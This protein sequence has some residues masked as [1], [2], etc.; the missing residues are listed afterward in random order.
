MSNAAKKVEGHGKAMSG[1]RSDKLAAQMEPFDSFWEGPEDVEKGYGSFKAFYRDNY[2]KH[3][4]PNKDAR[5]LVVS[6]GPGY[7]VN[8][9]N[10]AGYQDVIG[11]D[12]FDDKIEH[13]RFHGLNCIQARAFEYL[14]EQADETFDVIFCEQEL[15][16][17]TKDEMIEFLGLARAKLRAGGQLICH[18]LNGA[19]PIV[20]AETLAQNWDHQ[21]TFTSY[22]LNQVLEHTG[23]D[24]QKIF[25][26]HLYV[27][28]K[29]PA[30]YVA[31]GLTA[32]LHFVFQVLFKIYGK[33]N[34]IFEKKIAAVA[35]KPAGDSGSSNHLRSV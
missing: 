25:G 23:F 20:G 12:S 34:K 32:G 16:H 22:S 2:L 18:G 3:V 4:T 7:F 5:I 15:N 13:A 17:L 19:N 28:Y 24:V 11:I 14:A 6:C 9:L 31:W 27:F 10:Q 29:N 35:I 26:L 8:V 30:N 33:F 1:P 21:N